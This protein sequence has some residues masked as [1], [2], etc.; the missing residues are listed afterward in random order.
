MFCRAG[1]QGQFI[2][3]GDEWGVCCSPDRRA[4]LAV[5]HGIPVRGGDRGSSGRWQRGRRW[6]GAG[7]RVVRVVMV[8]RNGAVCGGA[9]R[10]QF[11]NAGKS[12]HGSGWL[13]VLGR[14]VGA[15]I[16]R[17]VASHSGHE[18]FQVGCCSE[19]SVD[20]GLLAAWQR[21]GRRSH[22]RRSTSLTTGRREGSKVLPFRRSGVSA[23]RRGRW[24]NSLLASS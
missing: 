19:G 1:G 2:R 20:M 21:E 8:R 11:S 15:G 5:V 23:R 17:P 9:C 22:K 6:G 4:G 13:G 24:M 16:A 18:C 10:Q 12:S 14:S 3:G 7:R